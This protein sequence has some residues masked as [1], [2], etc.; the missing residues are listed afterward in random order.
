MCYSWF[1]ISLLFYTNNLI[2]LWDNG[3]HFDLLCTLWSCKPVITCLFCSIRDIVWTVIYLPTPS[4]FLS[5]YLLLDLPEREA[6]RYKLRWNSK[7]TKTSTCFWHHRRES[8]LYPRKCARVLVW[9]S[10]GASSESVHVFEPARVHIDDGSILWSGFFKYAPYF[11]ASKASQ[12]SVVSSLPAILK[13]RRVVRFSAVSRRTF[14]SH[15]RYTQKRTN[16]TGW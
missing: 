8:A 10:R 6:A 14:W 9:P 11:E 3:T 16:P 1:P 13:W 2:Y 4:I 5:L 15:E 7:H 12:I